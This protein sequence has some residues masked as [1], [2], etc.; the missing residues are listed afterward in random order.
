MSHA[1]KRRSLCGK[2]DAQG[3]VTFHVCKLEEDSPKE[4]CVNCLHIATANNKCERVRLSEITPLF[5]EIQ[6]DG[7]RAEDVC[8]SNRGEH[9]QR[10]A[11]ADMRYPILIFSFT[12]QYG[13]ERLQ[14]V[15]GCHRLA[16]AYIERQ[17]TILCKR[18]T[19]EQLEQCV[20][21]PEA[22]SRPASPTSP[23]P[24]PSTLAKLNIPGCLKKPATLIGALAA[25]LFF[26]AFIALITLAATNSQQ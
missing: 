10:I 16:K 11:H 22:S 12:D 6:W 3:Q 18:V 9:W 8:H 17:L 4:Y 13:K 25:S 1:T 19:R 21:V 15:D 20:F 14:V 26:I 2:C 7:V 24:F 23:P 5:S